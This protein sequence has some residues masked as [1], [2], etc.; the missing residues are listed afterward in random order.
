MGLGTERHLRR[1]NENNGCD[2]RGSAKGRRIRNRRK[3]K[4]QRDKVLIWLQ[5]DQTPK[6]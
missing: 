1:L 5:L 4:P 2:A 6:S 3:R